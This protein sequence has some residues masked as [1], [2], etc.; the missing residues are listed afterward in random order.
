MDNLFN[1][2]VHLGDKL[3]ILILLWQIKRLF[4]KI[5]HNRA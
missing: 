4:W 1:G 5:E 3:Y 2:F